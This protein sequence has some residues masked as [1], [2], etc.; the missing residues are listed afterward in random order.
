MAISTIISGG[1]NG[2]DISGNIFADKY[3][4][5]NEVNIFKEFKHKIFPLS[6]KVNYVCDKHHYIGNLVCRTQYNIDHSDITIILIKQDIWTT[7][8]SL[9]TF[10]KCMKSKRDM[11]YFD[12][13]TEIGVCN[14]NPFLGCITKTVSISGMKDLLIQRTPAIINIAGQRELNEN[15]VISFLERILL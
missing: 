11:V 6:T 1:Q 8:G 9:L 2:A 15:N 7:K 4:I 13:Y 3:K 10:K 5:P 12:I 14:I